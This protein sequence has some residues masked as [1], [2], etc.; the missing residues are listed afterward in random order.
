M[1]DN[2]PTIFT[3]IGPWDR[4]RHA[5]RRKKQQRVATANKKNNVFAADGRGWY[6]VGPYHL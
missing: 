4:H 2:E 1:N 5:A 3:T 6:E